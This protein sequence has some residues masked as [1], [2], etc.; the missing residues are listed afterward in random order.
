M[1]VADLMQ[2]LGPPTNAAIASEDERVY[3]ASVVMS[4]LIASLASD[5]PFSLDALERV[6]GAICEYEAGSLPTLYKAS[7]TTDELVRALEPIALATL[8]NRGRVLKASVVLSTLI[9]CLEAEEEEP[10]NALAITAGM[11]PGS[12]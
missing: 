6:S 8:A 1:T 10:L 11:L 5:E 12:Q 9:G 2:A 3:Q 7:M 4:A